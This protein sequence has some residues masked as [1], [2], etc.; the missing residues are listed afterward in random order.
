MSISQIIFQN[1]IV[2]KELYLIIIDFLLDWVLIIFLN[3]LLIKYIL[4]F[5]IAEIIS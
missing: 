4:I 2:F 3:C 5:S 1:N